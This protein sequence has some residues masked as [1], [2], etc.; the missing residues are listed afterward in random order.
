MGCCPPALPTLAPQ[1]MSER[2]LRNRGPELPGAAPPSLAPYSVFVTLAELRAIQR[3]TSGRHVAFNAWACG[4]PCSQPQAAVAD[5][6]APGT[7]RRAAPRLAHNGGGWGLA[8]R[9]RRALTCLGASS[10][11]LASLPCSALPRS[12]AARPSPTLDSGGQS[13]SAAG[14]GQL[15][16][17]CIPSPALPGS[18]QH[19]STAFPAITRNEQAG[20]CLRPPAAGCG[21]STRPGRL[22]R[23]GTSQGAARF[24][25]AG[26]PGCQ[27]ALQAPAG[28]TGSRRRQ[29]CRRSRARFNPPPASPT[30]PAAWTA[31]TWIGWAARAAPPPAAPPSCR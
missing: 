8:W 19:F 2:A 15:A 1:T 24:T 25:A 9:R 6:G 29:L 22:V 10:P 14:L 23:A 7:A 12:A 17:A 20:D 3:H 31:S 5:V 16:A 13:R 21:G 27:P 4:Q 30:R 11:G 18:Q 28:H 26:W